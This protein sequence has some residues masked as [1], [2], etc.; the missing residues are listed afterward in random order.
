M[1]ELEKKQADCPK[2]GRWLGDKNE[3]ERELE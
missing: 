3:N 1:K 2:C